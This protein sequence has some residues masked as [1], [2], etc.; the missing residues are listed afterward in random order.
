MDQKIINN[1]VSF[2]RTAGNG[3]DKL[4][5]RHFDLSLF[6]VGAYPSW[7]LQVSIHDAQVNIVV[8]PP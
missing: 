4:T 3:S 5:D 6:H 1:D 7:V 8:K 2:L